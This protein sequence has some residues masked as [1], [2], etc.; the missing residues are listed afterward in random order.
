VLAKQTFRKVGQLFINE[1]LARQV[2]FNG[3]VLDGYSQLSAEVVRLRS[4]VAELEQ[5][6]EAS[7]APA[8]VKPPVLKVD[9]PP[10]PRAKKADAKP[11]RPRSK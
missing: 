11:R 9:A 3:H 7:R 8:P 1:A 6:L 10:R 5:A 2:V 4:R